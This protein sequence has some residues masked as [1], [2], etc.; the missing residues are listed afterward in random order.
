MSCIPKILDLKGNKEYLSVPS[1]KNSN[2]CI[3]V[4]I[5]DGGHYKGFDFLVTFNDMGFR[6]GYVALPLSHVA[7][8]H[9]KD[10][11]DYDVHGGITFYDKNH[12]SK[13]F[14]GE[15]ACKD[16]WLGF[17]C[18]HAGDFC[19]LEKAKEYFKD[20]KNIFRGIIEVQ[21]IKQEVAADMERNYP[22]YL[23][24]KNSPD[25]E[26]REYPRTK[27]YVINECKSLIDQL[28]EKISCTSA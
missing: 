26:W 25:Y 22:G 16:K 3:G 23:N 17:D 28:I 14:F 8:N 12:F 19:D 6:C 13:L 7:N 15:D 1:K 4:V 27:E 21:K 10:Y 11:P 24:R 18:G 20:N 2:D 9:K 5:E